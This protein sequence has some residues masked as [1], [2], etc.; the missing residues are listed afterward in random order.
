MNEIELNKAAEVKLVYQTKV[1]ASDRPRVQSSHD[2]YKILKGIFDQETIEHHESVVLLLLNRSNRVLGA[3]QI[4]TG[5]INGCIMDVR[6]ILQYCLIANATG[7]IISHNH[8]SGNLD[9]SDSDKN[10]TKKLKTASSYHDLSFTDH[11][12][13]TPENKYTSFADE[14]YL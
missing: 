3:K 14:G 11:I 10:I 6:L 8:P 2:A 13:V 4:S 9:P 12:I 1:K 7:F 5:G